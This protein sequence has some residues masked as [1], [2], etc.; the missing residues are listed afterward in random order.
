MFKSMAAVA[1]ATVGGCLLVLVLLPSHGT[2]WPSGKADVPPGAGP[3]RADIMGR[4]VPAAPAEASGHDAPAG[5]SAH[6]RHTEPE[7]EPPAHAPPR[8]WRIA[9]NGPAPGLT[10]RG[11]GGFSVSW[12]N[13]T[14]REVDVWL[15]VRHGNRM[16]RMAQVAPRAGAG[17]TGEALVSLPPVAPGRAYALEVTTQDDIAH[18]YST[19]FAVIA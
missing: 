16:Q 8:G 1:V 4:G 3:A 17:P 9:V 18:A 7:E 5:H 12:T 15:T 10:F 13:N 2:P 19:S 6:S 14:G 11:N